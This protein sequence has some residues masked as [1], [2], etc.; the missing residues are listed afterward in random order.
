MT[1]TENYILLVLAWAIYFFLHSFLVSTKIKNHLIDVGI[2]KKWQRVFYNLI[3]IIGLFSIMFFNGTIDSKLLFVKNEVLKVIAL[4]ITAIG[5]IIIR[6]SF[7][8]YSIKSFLG[9]EKEDGKLITNKGILKYVRHPIYSGTILVVLGYFLYDPRVATL[10]TLICIYIYLFIGIKLEENKLL[11]IYGSAYK[12]YR[13]DVPA[14]F[15]RIR[16]LF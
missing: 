10:I 12:K 2:G 8:Y 3:A 15:P 13:K 14:L 11:K 16:N 6:Q 5:I 9:L 1:N 7:K 4:I